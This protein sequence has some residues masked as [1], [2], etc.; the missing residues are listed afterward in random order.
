MLVLLAGGCA[1]SRP[2]ARPLSA[3]TP[4][5]DV[6]AY[7]DPPTGWNPDPLKAS[8]THKHRVWLSPSGH[9]AYGIIH[10]SLPLPV[11]HDLALWGFLR[12]M[13]R[14]EGEA[15]LISKQWDQNLPGLRFVAM[16]GLYCVRVNLVVDGFEGWAVYAGTLRR[17]EVEPDELQ[18][19]EAAR[20]QTRVKLAR[21]DQH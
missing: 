2:T 8:G 3:L 14:S 18:L 15:T 20:D 5:Q 10:F 13:K 6:D 1:A 9:S 12:E 7:V 21:A 11:G 19:A 17:F 4:D 16:G